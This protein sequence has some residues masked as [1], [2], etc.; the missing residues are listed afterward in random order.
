MPDGGQ[1]T[2]SEQH[3]C[4]EC[5]AY[6]PSGDEVS[7]PV[8]EHKCGRITKL[9]AL[10]PET[11]TTITVSRKS[12]DRIIDEHIRLRRLVEHYK[13][14]IAALRP[15]AQVMAE[16][17]AGAMK[18]WPDAPPSTY[19]CEHLSHRVGWIHAAKHI[20]TAILARLKE[21]STG[22]EEAGDGEEAK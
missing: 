2:H 21:L 22:T 3:I 4:P 8:P 14:E 13:K 18:G 11:T 20:P 1:F 12:V 16:I 6:L 19:K 15:K 7:G 9:V 10:P 5:G 17:E